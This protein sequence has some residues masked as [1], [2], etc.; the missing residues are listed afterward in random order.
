MQSSEIE[1]EGIKELFNKI[2]PRY[3]F[4]NHFLSF[5]IDKIWRTKAI[6]LIPDIS[7]CEKILDVACG[8]G[9]FSFE[10][11]KQ[12]AKN[13]IGYDISE[14]M[15]KI[16]EQKAKKRDLLNKIN[17]QLGNSS[18][19]P[20]ENQTFDAVIIAFG[21]RNFEN[22]NDELKEILRVL[23]N[24]GLLLILEFSMPENWFFRTIYKFYFFKILPFFGG[25]FSGN[26]KAYQYLPNSVET[27]PQGDEFLK[28]L[29][30]IGFKNRQKKRLSF[31]IA[32]IYLGKACY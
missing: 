22:R 23:K 17:F 1:K 4:L 12:G 14:E 20:F 10:A 30:E 19:F 15:L 13:V 18:I 6:R 11:I 31:G 28:V 21:V 25:L 2:A 8:T 24:N 29:S 16:A 27:F 9:D 7:N 5:G 26:K 3:D 32:H